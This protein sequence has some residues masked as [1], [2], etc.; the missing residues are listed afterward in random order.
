MWIRTDD[1]GWSHDLICDALWIGADS[2]IMLSLPNL[3]C[4]VDWKGC[5]KKI[6]RTFLSTM[7]LRTNDRE[8]CHDVIWSDMWI[9][10]DDI[11]CCLEQIYIAMCIGKTMTSRFRDN[12]EVQCGL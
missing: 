4:F 7:W 11:G 12:F 2:D 6:S 1:R 10:R 8:W 3:K 5:G 9:G